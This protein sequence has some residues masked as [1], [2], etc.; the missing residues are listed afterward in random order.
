[1]PERH[2]VSRHPVLRGK[3]LMMIKILHYPP[4]NPTCGSFKRDLTERVYIPKGT[5]NPDLG[6]LVKEVC[7]E[8][9]IMGVYGE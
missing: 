3:S 9:T 5:P 8:A 6:V 2:E 4:L 1:M 7:L